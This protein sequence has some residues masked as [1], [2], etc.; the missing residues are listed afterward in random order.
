MAI[1]KPGATAS[2]ASE[3]SDKRISDKLIQLINN[4]IKVEAESSQ[5]YF[6]ISQWCK[7]VGYSNSADLFEKYT[8]EE[9][10]H[11]KKFYEYLQDRDIHPITPDISKPNIQ[12]FN[13]LADVFIAAYEHEKFV[14][15][16]ISTIA[17]ACSQ[18][19]DYMTLEFAMAFLKEQKEE[20]A[21]TKLYVDQLNL[22]GTDKLSLYLFDKE[23]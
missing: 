23:L 19:G 2:T 12:T 5:L 11:M 4:Q 16:T 8:E 22:L 18:E 15:N 6:A 9:R 1:I 17:T 13:N 10:A 21:K 7:F 3:A 20:E 14:T